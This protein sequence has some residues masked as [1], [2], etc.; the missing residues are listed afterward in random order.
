LTAFHDRGDVRAQQGQEGQRQRLRADVV[1]RD[2]PAQRADPADGAQEIGGAGRERALGD[3]QDDPQLTRSRSGDGHQVV[4]RSGVEDLRLHVD[5]QRQRREQPLLDRPPERRPTAG[6]VQ[7][8]EATGPPGGGEQC[9]RAVQRPCVWSA[10]Q[11]RNDA[12][13]C[14]PSPGTCST[15]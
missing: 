5:E 2:R 14:L 7:L 1:H 10:A 12:K 8:G 3:L 15:P 13:T 9:V 4:E 6:L 11:V